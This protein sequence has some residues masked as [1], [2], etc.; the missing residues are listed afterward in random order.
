MQE[1]QRKKVLNSFQL[2]LRPIVK[3]LLRYGIGFSE[4]AE[5]VKTAYVDVSSSDF[6]IRGRPTNI[7]RV[8]VMTGLTRKE[9]RRL[10]TKIESGD[11]QVTVKSTPIT[12]ILHR[13][14]AEDEFLNAQ[15]RPA[16]LPFSGEEKSFSSLVKKFGGDVPAGAMRAELKRVGSIDEDSDG[17]LTVKLRSFWPSDQTQ[18]LESAL[19]HHVYPLLS[20]VSYNTDPSNDKDAMPQF[21]AYSLN[22]NIEDRP[23]IKRMCSDRLSD[24]AESFDDLFIAYESRGAERKEDDG[25]PVMVGVYYF[26]ERDDNAN[27]E[28]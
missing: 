17:N 21:A 20:N 15:G 27:Y 24:I 18:K 19:I 26:E 12:E 14:H 13:W 11:D 28:W 1:K 3:I 8:A 16:T 2:V 7:S 5:T 4:F 6:G 25:T 23:R 9:V 22:I 10:R